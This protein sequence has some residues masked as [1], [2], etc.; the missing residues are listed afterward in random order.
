V[1]GGTSEF[2]DRYSVLEG[3]ISLSIAI[4]IFY[5]IKASKS[6]VII[7]VLLFSYWGII[8]SF[9]VILDKETDVLEKL[10]S[11]SLAVIQFIFE[12]YKIKIFSKVETK[13]Y[14]KERGVTIVT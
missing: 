11:R 8:D 10:V 13:K 14:F 6:W 2:S 1:I 12:I 4:G 5:G 7:L 3:C 9:L